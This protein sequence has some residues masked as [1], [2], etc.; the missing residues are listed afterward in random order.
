MPSAAKLEAGKAYSQFPPAMEVV[1]QTSL[2]LPN[3][4]PFQ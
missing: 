2:P 1:F 4:E 3:E